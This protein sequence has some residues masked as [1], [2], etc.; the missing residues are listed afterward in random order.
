MSW[1]IEA[2]ARQG[3]GD[4]DAISAV[5]T[6]KTGAGPA[7]RRCHT[8]DTRNRGG[9]SLATRLGPEG[10]IKHAISSF[11]ELYGVLFTLHLRT[12]NRRYRSR[13]MRNGWPD[14][15]GVCKCGKAI[16]IEVKGPRGTIA[17]EQYEIIREA[18]KRGAHA[19][20][21]DSIDDVKRGIPCL[22]Y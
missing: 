11:L 21:A 1:Q 7:I 9:E 4:R 18:T 13:H 10:E 5:R 20:V 8:D 3:E 14:I 15:H 17:K 2:Y 6:D 16:L 19:M 12:H 22:G